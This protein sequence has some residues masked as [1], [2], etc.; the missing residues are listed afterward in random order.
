[1]V[2]T[3]HGGGATRLQPTGP[4]AE[5]PKV[6]RTLLD[7]AE[8]AHSGGASSIMFLPQQGVRYDAYAFAYL[9]GLAKELNIPKPPKGALRGTLVINIAG[10]ASGGL[11]DRVTGWAERQLAKEGVRVGLD[12]KRF[13]ALRAA[14]QPSS[15][16]TFEGRTISLPRATLDKMRRASLHSEDSELLQ[17]ASWGNEALRKHFACTNTYNV[18][19]RTADGK[20]THV[21][22][23]PR[24][25]PMR[26]EFVT[27]IPMQIPEGAGDVMLE[28]WPTGFEVQSYVEARRYQVHMGE[29][30]FDMK[31]AIETANAYQAKY[32]SIRWNTDHEHDDL[33]R[34]HISPSPFP[35]EDF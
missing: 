3:V 17:L 13:Q 24:N 25:D 26:M 4:F 32:P 34:Q 6:A 19:L 1:M 30:L 33:D 35:Y 27:R 7:L 2:S 28:A 15:S 9:T 31:G 23:I 5:N 22:S 11:G 21:E 29:N 8:R 14:A 12:V 18:R 10:D 20:T 16:I